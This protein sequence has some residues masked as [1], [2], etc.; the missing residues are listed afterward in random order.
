MS[1]ETYEVVKIIATFR[2][3][4]V[5]PPRKDVTIFVIAKNEAISK[6]IETY[7]VFETS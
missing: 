6:P 7:E 5:V 4:F 3:Y 1:I 2:D